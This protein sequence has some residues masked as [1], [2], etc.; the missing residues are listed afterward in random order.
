MRS[1]RE[2][3]QLVS[4][5]LDRR[6]SWRERISVWMHVGMCSLCRTYRRQ[7]LRLN[8]L[9]RGA[10]RQGAPPGAV[11]D[12]GLSDEAKQDIKSRLSSGR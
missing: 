9:V 12:D 5:S 7:V 1:C 8:R 11:S 3:S 10:F 2:V 4:E 6:L